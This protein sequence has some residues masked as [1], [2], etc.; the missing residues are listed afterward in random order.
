LKD[1]I[2]RSKTLSGFDAPYVPGWDCHGLPIEHQIEKL[3]GKNIPADQVRELCRTYAAEQVERQKKDFIRLGVLGD[4]DNPYLTM[5]FKAEAEEIRAL[6]KILEQGY[7]YQGLK[8]V[9]WCLDCGSALAEAEVEYEDKTSPAID[10][11]FEVHENHA[12]KLAHAFG[13]THLR[14]PAFA[15]IWTTTPWTLPA[16]EAVSVHPELTYDLIETEK[17][18]LILVRELAEAALKRYELAGTVVASVTGDKLDQ[19]LLKHPFQAR[20]V[21]IICG[22]HV[23]TEAGTGLVHTAPA[24]GVDDYNVGRQYR[25]PVNNPVGND[26]KFISTVPALSTGELAGKS[27]WEANPLVLAELAVRG[28]LL[29]EEKIRHSYPHC[30]RHKT[31]LIYRATAQWF[32]GMDKVAHDGSSLRRRALD[33]IEQTE[34]VPAWGQARLHGM[35]AGRPDWCI[36]RQRNWGVPIPFF[37]HKETGQPHPRTAELVELV[38]QRV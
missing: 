16:N 13:L 12:E 21:A 22:K 23:T 4:W 1:I 2:V 5:N 37:L 19:I 20:D 7:L 38:A 18:A 15:V 25:L 28:R 26:G 30:W 33:A 6:G 3:H 14:G 11:A 9:N 32:V 36:S 35:I 24:H 34:F 17:G 10:V 27:V 29:F 31:P 8:P